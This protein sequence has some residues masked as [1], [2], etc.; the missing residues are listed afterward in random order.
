MVDAPSNL[1][2]EAI[3]EILFIIAL[4]TPFASTPGCE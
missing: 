2:E 1:L 4:K 3:L